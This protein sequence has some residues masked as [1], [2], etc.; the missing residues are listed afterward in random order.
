MNRKLIKNESLQR[1]VVLRG[2]L[3]IVFL[4][5]IGLGSNPIASAATTDVVTGG[6]VYQQALGGVEMDADRVLANAPSKLIFTRREHLI[7]YLQVIPSDLNQATP[8]RKVSLKKLHEEIVR[9]SQSESNEKLSDAVRYLGGLTSIQKIVAVPEEN[10]ILLIGPAEGW[11]YDQSGCLVGVVS[12]KPILQLEDLITLMRI[13]N[14]P[15]PEV[16][17]C[18]IDPTPDARLRVAQLQRDFNPTAS[19]VEEYRRNLEIAFGL[20]D[21]VFTGI[22]GNCRIA[23][24]MAAADFKLKQI[25]IGDPNAPKGFNSYLSMVR[26]NS[27]FSLNPRFWMAPEYG[28]ISHDVERL[29]WDLSQ[30]SVKIMTEAGYIDMNGNRA[31][32]G[33]ADTA[34]IRWA[35]KMTKDFP[36]LCST[37][38]TFADLKNCMDLAVAVALI[39]KENLITR[40]GCPANTLWDKSAIVFPEYLVPARVR[41]TG[42]VEKKAGGFVVGCG[43][44]EINPWKKL[45]STT[46]NE[47]LARSR[48]SLITMRGEKFWSN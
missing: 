20:N 31:Q 35:E 36:K 42:V 44:I 21:I 7:K 46:L 25:G 37:D 5:I 14:H 47:D 48:Q 16:I 15:R 13:W 8:L 17:T 6:T 45:E 32:K 38:S 22:P 12:G 4:L 24:I 41:S 33:L 3:S 18:S 26:V 29:T 23:R 30:S 10:D 34:A 39:Y 19:N 11:K 9:C 40:T 28:T 43:G 1:S 2:V 27:K